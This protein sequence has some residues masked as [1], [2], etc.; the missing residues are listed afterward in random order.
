MAVTPNSLQPT[1]CKAFNTAFA[2]RKIPAVGTMGTGHVYC[3]Y[4]KSGP[5]ST[6]KLGVFAS[7]RQTGLEFCR[8]FRPGH[9]FGNDG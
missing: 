1:A 2:G 9:G 7:S 4:S 5:S 8:S 6:V 3:R